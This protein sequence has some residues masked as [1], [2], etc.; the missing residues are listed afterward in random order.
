MKSSQ[1]YHFPSRCEKLMLTNF[2]LENLLDEDDIV[3][4]VKEGK[5]TVLE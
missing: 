1:I 2:T 5:M 4:D 3:I